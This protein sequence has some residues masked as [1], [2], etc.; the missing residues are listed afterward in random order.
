MSA[1][2]ISDSPGPAYLDWVGQ[3][4][5]AFA[6]P[7][8]AE[9]IRALGGGPLF[10]WHPGL[11][12]GVLLAVFHRGPMRFGICGQPVAGATWDAMSNA[13]MTALAR[14]LCTVASLDVL[15][16]NRSTRTAA[17]DGA[18]A[19][20]PEF[21]ISDLDQWRTEASSKRRK[22]LTRARRMMG[23]N[24]GVL[25]GFDPLAAYALYAATVSRHDGHLRYNPAYFSAV[26]S[27]SRRS[28]VVRCLSMRS[29]GGDLLGFAV[30]AFDNGVAYYLH[31]GVGEEGRRLGGSDLLLEVMVEIAREAGCRRFSLMASPWEQPGLLSFKEKWSDS[32]GLSVTHDVPG[33][34]LGSLACRWLR[35]GVGRDA[36]AA[37]AFLKPQELPTSG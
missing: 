14:A 16:L 1:W 22:D 26:E 4:P 3:V 29:A 19:L 32:R 37:R 9:V 35:R 27:L 21:L 17:V 34:W 15:R 12:A 25:S 5:R 13:D 2:Q 6:D 11:G 23:A 30:L 10:A 18:S 28:G 24:V 33:K 20:R 8:W 36:K 31:G 7:N